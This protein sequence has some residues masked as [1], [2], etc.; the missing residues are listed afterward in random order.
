MD[1][2][3]ALEIEESPLYYLNRGICYRMMGKLG[4]S[5][6]DL[7]K[8]VELDPKTHSYYLHR[9]ITYNEMDKKKEVFKYDYFL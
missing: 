6:I 4:K 3:I 9:G 7:K 1:F 5:L 2:D 8:A